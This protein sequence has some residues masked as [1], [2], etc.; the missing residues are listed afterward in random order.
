MQAPTYA[1][2][3]TFKKV[4][5]WLADHA[6]HLVSKPEPK[7]TVEPGQKPGDNPFE[8]FDRFPNGANV[9]SLEA[10]SRA[11]RRLSEQVSRQCQSRAQRIAAWI[12]L[13]ILAEP[14]GNGIWLTRIEF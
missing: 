3:Q 5:T 10:G 1:E 12:K 13:G 7:V 2:L 8:I 9:R 6:T 14:A 4:A 11:F